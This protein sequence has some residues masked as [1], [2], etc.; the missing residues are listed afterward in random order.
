MK[1][2]LLMVIGYWMA[3]TQAM[4][5]NPTISSAFAILRA[6]PTAWRHRL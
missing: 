3:T 6:A 1:A 2:F 4:A 5:Q